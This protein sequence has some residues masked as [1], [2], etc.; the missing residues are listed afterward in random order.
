[1]SRVLWATD[2]HLDAAEFDTVEAFCTSVN[3]QSAKALLLGGDIADG[4]SLPEWLAFLADRIDLPI[5][6]VLGNH[7]FY[8]SSIDDVRSTMRD[9]NDPRIKWLPHH[10]IVNLAEGVALVGQDGWGDAR[11]GHF[12]HSDVILTDYL[13]IIDLSNAFDLDSFNGD[14][15]NQRKLKDL[16]GRLGDDE[17]GSLRPHLTEAT[18][19]SRRVVVLTHVPPF[20]EACWYHG[21][22]SDD[23]WL[24]SL[25]CKA[26]GD[27]LY[28]TAQANPHCEVVVLC[29]H[30]HGSGVADILPNLRVFTGE[31]SYGQ[32]YFKTVKVDQS[33]VTVA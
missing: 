21:G 13:A 27:L 30:T 17:A 7:D 5:Y 18:A 10:G 14:L 26:V 9:L 25:T 32:V 3:A 22:I 1:M 29:G 6:F 15:S 12:F 16:L 19:R 24:P 11:L 8:G 33:M 20:R 23:N 28:E 4:S 31:A 2:I